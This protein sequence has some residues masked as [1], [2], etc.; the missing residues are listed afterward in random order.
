MRVFYNHILP[1][2]AHFFKFSAAPVSMPGGLWLPTPAF[3]TDVGTPA[4]PGAAADHH[5]QRLDLGRQAVLDEPL[6]GPSRRLEG[7]GTLSQATPEMVLRRPSP[8]HALGC[9]T[10]F[11]LDLCTCLW[12][13]VGQ[14][15]VA[16]PVFSE[17]AIWLHRR[18][19]YLAQGGY[20]RLHRSGD[21]TPMNTLQQDLR[22]GA[23]PCLAKVRPLSLGRGI[24]ESAP[25][26]HLL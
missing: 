5:V 20:G 23:S 22:Q 8:N 25:Q 14:V 26:L 1:L 7:W 17:P 24:P 21:G 9:E 6:A 3:A 18:P 13:L 11:V 15:S 16:G 10:N 12:R 4:A 2:V 19:T